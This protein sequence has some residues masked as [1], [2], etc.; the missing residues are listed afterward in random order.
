M[1]YLDSEGYGWNY[2]GIWWGADAT[3]NEAGFRVGYSP[4]G[5]SGWALYA[6]VGADV[7]YFQQQFSAYDPLRPCQRLA[8]CLGPLNCATVFNDSRA[9]T[10]HHAPSAPAASNWQVSTTLVDQEIKT[11]ANVRRIHGV[12]SQHAHRK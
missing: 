1:F 10:P 5:Q 4:D 7:N 3:N 12:V 11:A 6:T 2:P 9:L 8:T